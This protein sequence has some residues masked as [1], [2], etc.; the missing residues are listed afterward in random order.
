M[1]RLTLGLRLGSAAIVLAAAAVPA[2]A[3]APPAERPLGLS[4]AARLA[5]EQAPALKS[6]TE[7]VA[8]RQGAVRE[9]RGAFDALLRLAPAFTHTEDDIGLLFT[10]VLFGSDQ[11]LSR[12]SFSIAASLEKPLR[13][14]TTLRLDVSVTNDDALFSPPLAVI[15]GDV[16]G[17]LVDRVEASWVQ[18]LLRGRGAVTAQAAELSATR[19]L[20]A[21]RFEF[22]QASADQVLTATDRYVGLVAARE[23]LALVRQSLDSQRGLLEGTIK[24]VAAGEVP[25]SEATRARARTLE[26]EA[27]VQAALVTVLSAQAALADALGLPPEALTTL[28]ASDAFAAEPLALDADAA[29]KAAT[30]RRADVKALAAA[31]AAGR[32][33]QAAARADLRPRLDLTV[34]GGATKSRYGSAGRFLAPSSTPWGAIALVQASFEL[35]FGNNRQAGGYAQA[36]ASVADREIRLAELGRQVVNA[37]ARY[38]ED[39]RRARAEWTARQEA[40]TAYEATWN[41]ALRLRAAGELSLV[42]TLLTEQQL[43]QARLLLVDAKRAYAL[44]LAHFKRETGTLVAFTDGSPGQPELAGIL[45]SRE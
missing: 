17:V 37:V 15:G 9:A 13:T 12:N 45:A 40:V 43:L 7:A 6:A 32:V 33:L 36:T 21:S 23:S 19:S 18:P 38:S 29:S 10:S 14:G 4:Q 26:G 41:T 30:S 22:Q 11:R 44:A 8:V 16:P 24:L 3:Q 1:T 28:A 20:E 34:T 2:A 5:L 31:L 39:L 42:D 27:S 25:R 35:P